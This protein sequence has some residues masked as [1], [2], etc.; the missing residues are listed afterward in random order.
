MSSSVRSSGLTFGAV[1]A[2]VSKPEYICTTG[3]VLIQFPKPD[4]ASG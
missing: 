2:T 1:F 4:I 3:I